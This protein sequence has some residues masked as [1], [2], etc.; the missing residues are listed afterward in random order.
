[1]WEKQWVVHSQPAGRGHEAIGYLARYVQNTALGGKAI[2]ADDERGVAF[3][4]T[5]N[6]SGAR[7]R[8]TLQP[9]EFLRRILSH[10]LPEGLHKVRYFGWLHP[11]ARRRYHQVALLLEAIILLTHPAPLHPP[12]HLR[13]PHCGACALQLVGRLRRPR[14]P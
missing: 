5:E 4:Y 12:L 2:V 1:V 11:N 6:G 3:T 13:C 9:L 8:M 14:P 7:K 10:V